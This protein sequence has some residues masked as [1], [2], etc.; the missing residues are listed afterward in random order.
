MNNSTQFP[1]LI[2]QLTPSNSVW[3]NIATNQWFTYFSTL[4]TPDTDLAGD[5]KGNLNLSNAPGRICLPQDRQNELNL[6]FTWREIKNSIKNLKSGKLAGPDELVVEMFKYGT[7]N[8]LVYLK[9]LFDTIFTNSQFPEMWIKYTIIP[10]H[11]KGSFQK[12]DN[13]KGISLTSIF[14]N[15]FT[16]VLNARL[17][18]WANT[19]GVISDDQ[20]GFR[21]G[22]STIDNVFILHCVIQKYLYIKRKKCMWPL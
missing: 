5:D 10:V 8:F 1:K 2:S 15:I 3:N 6:N 13:Y 11:K 16:G 9:R 7:D 20:A 19:H 4:F 21:E 17:Q 14:S 18:A 12:P 22:Y